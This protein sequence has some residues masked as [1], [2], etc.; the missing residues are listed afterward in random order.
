MPTSPCPACP[1]DK[2]SKQNI[3]NQKE[4]EKGG[5]KRK[6]REERGKPTVEDDEAQLVE[7][8]NPTKKLESNSVDLVSGK[9]STVNSLSEELFAFESQMKFFEIPD[10]EG[11]WDASVD[12]FLYD[13]TTQDGGN[14]VDLWMFGDF[15][16]VLGEF[17]EHPLHL[18]F[19]PPKTC[20]SRFLRTIFGHL[21]MGAPKQKWT[22]EEEA[23][24]KAGIAK[25]GAG[26][27][28]TI[29]KD[30]Q[31]STILRSR[32]N[33][34][35]KDKWRNMN[36]MASGWGSR[37]RA[38]LAIKSNQVT[39]KHDE[40]STTHS[41]PVEE[42]V[43]AR[44]VEI[45]GGP[46]ENGSDAAPVASSHEAM[47][48]VVYDVKPLATSQG[49]LQRVGSKKPISRLDNLILEAITN[50]KEPH[51]SNRTAI[52]MYIEEQY[53]APLNFERLLAT[54]LKLLTENR[55]LIK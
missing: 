33:V 34:D 38:R 9:E 32:S 52:A 51:G 22:S 54:N 14:P 8:A 30:P 18:I 50:L 45:S 35:L 37:Q 17:S 25:Y 47:Q 1:A 55:K 11:N 3:S 39:P 46:L 40:N 24:L 28:S 49:P 15:P 19:L 31:F 42:I 10:L 16:P 6:R 53:M 5:K 12:T 13:S 48:N 36:V 43:H 20:A 26:K 44:P 2:G 29:L 27:W 7:D 23:A 41:P 4:E 21:L